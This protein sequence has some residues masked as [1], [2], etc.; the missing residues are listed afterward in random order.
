MTIADALAHHPARTTFDL[1]ELRRAIE[2]VNACSVQCSLCADSDLARDPAGMADCIRRCLDCADIAGT[3][4]RILS[5][6]TPN[7]HA[8]RGLVEAC[9]LACAECAAACRAHDHPCCQACAAA[10]TEAEQ[11]LQ[12]LLAAATDA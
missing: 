3:T 5:R 2:A 8:W 6:P 10:C 11:A 7:G 1:A 9:A 4:A 12:Q